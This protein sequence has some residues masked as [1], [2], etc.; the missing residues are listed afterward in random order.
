MR[1]AHRNSCARNKLSL[2]PR[3]IILTDKV[4]PDLVVFILL[5][6]ICGVTFRLSL[7]DEYSCWQPKEMSAVAFGFR[8]VNLLKHLLRSSSRNFH[9]NSSGQ[10]RRKEKVKLACKICLGHHEQ[11]SFI[12][13]RSQQQHE[14]L[15]AINKQQQKSINDITLVEYRY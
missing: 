9:N 10:T 15:N 1:N 5:R 13:L 7:H 6:H 14:M 11:F 4:F 8:N 12:A 3:P 2:P